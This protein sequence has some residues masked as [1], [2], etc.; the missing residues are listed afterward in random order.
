ME[1][2]EEEEEGEEDG[3]DGVEEDVVEGEEEAEEADDD[4]DDD[5]G[6]DTVPEAKANHRGQGAG[7]GRSRGQARG[8][9]LPSF[10]AGVRRA[11]PPRSVPAARAAAGSKGGARQVDKVLTWRLRAAGAGVSL[12]FLA[13]SAPWPKWGP[14]QGRM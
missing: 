10:V 11:T 3:I 9:A 6:A 5:H 7:G 13:R 8:K 1:G 14:L 2:E 12:G 4:E